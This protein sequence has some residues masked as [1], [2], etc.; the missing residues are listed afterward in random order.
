[1]SLTQSC[2]I[3]I[4]VYNEELA[5]RDTIDRIRKVTS[6]ITGFTFNVI[7][8]NDG[9]NDKSGD[10]LM[11]ESGITVIHHQVNRGYGATLKTGLL[12]A[13]EDWIFIVDADGTY[14]LEEI[15]R[16]LAECKED[17]HM[18]VGAR[19][20]IGITVS[21]F[22][23][24]ARWI[25][26]KMVHGLTGV[27]VPD[28]NSGMR[29][30]R[31]KLYL[32]FRHLLPMGFSFTT[33][34]TVAALYSGF[35]TKYLPIAYGHRTSTSK[36]RPFRDFLAF[37]M[38]IIRVASY[39]EPLR[40]FLPLAFGLASLGVFRAVRD[41][42]VTGQIGSLSLIIFM[43]SLQMFGLGV[44]ADITVKRSSRAPSEG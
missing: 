16:L 35:T 3:I 1:M 21:P 43:T 15:P 18:V 11:S 38:L 44:I 9:S 34:I 5:I 31:R 2:S 40:F 22:H 13:A 10:I 36:I 27:M 19:K 25:L 6:Q 4:P 32:E 29:F 12:H 24:F 26:R 30:F 37:V 20:G 14:P 23:R 33:T 39:F 17:V 7:C 41:Y 42:M 8:V 28:L